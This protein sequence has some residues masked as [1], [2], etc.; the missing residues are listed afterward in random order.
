MAD[1]QHED[2]PNTDREP[3]ASRAA[4]GALKV[5]LAHLVRGTAIAS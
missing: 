1:P 3:A 4:D 2:K 5:P